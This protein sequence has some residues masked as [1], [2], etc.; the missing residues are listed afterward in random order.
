MEEQ[1]KYYIVI[2]DE[3]TI[4]KYLEYSWKYDIIEDLHDYHGHIGRINLDI[5]VIFLI[6]G[7]TMKNVNL[8]NMLDE[9]F[10]TP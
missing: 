9:R 6:R 3:I 5:T 7:F 10:K 8:T 2:F 1:E 4:K